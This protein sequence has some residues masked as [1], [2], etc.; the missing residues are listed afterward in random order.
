MF[1]VTSNKM[2]KSVVVTVTYLRKLP[3][4][5][6]FRKFQ[7]KIMVGTVII[8]AL[9]TFLFRHIMNSMNA[10]LEILSKSNL[11]GL[12]ILQLYTF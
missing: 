7:S 1:K 6:V 11:A 5:H 12:V 4:Y 2:M 8:V 9:S 3:K 10:I